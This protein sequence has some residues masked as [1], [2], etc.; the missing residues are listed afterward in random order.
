MDSHVLEN[1]AAGKVSTA[2]FDLQRRVVVSQDRK[3]KELGMLLVEVSKSL[4]PQPTDTTQFNPEQ[5]SNSKVARQ[6]LLY[7]QA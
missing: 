6:E 1:V 4:I 2:D 7:R 5:A 3:I